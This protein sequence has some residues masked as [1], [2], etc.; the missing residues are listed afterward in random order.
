MRRR[1]RNF[2]DN[3]RPNE[4]H[5]RQIWKRRKKRS[6]WLRRAKDR[7]NAGSM[8][9][10]L[11]GFAGFSRFVLQSERVRAQTQV[12]K[13]HGNIQPER[14]ITTSIRVARVRNGKAPPLR[15]NAGFPRRPPVA[16]HRR[17]APVA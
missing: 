12:T 10:L 16:E 15:A 1:S 13:E 11:I 8:V 17:S 7:V 2:D 3:W 9:R 14:P 5:F 4:N 6:A